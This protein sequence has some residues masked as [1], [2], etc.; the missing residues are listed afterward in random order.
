VAAPRFGTPRL[1]ET[2]RGASRLAP[3]LTGLHTMVS[4]NRK[5][6]ACLRLYGDHSRR[7][8][9]RMLQRWTGILR[10]DPTRH[11]L[12]T[13]ATLAERYSSRAEKRIRVSMYQDTPAVRQVRAIAFLHLA[14]LTNVAQVSFSLLLVHLPFHIINLFLDSNTQ[15]ILKN[16][17]P[18]VDPPTHG[19]H[20]RRHFQ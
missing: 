13:F 9:Y 10:S 8:E 5:L 2:V 16:F 7:L 17:L 15:S 14:H 12:R 11:R 20:Y 3:G 19:R 6:G 4:N 1:L 18:R